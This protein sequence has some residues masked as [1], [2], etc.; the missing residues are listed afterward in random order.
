MENKEREETRKPGT[1]TSE[2]AKEM[3]ARS[4]ESRHRNRLLRDALNE[5]LMRPVKVVLSDGSVTERERFEQ[6]VRAIGDKFVQGD[7]D[8]VKLY[9]KLNGELADRVQLEN[10]GQPFELKVVKVSEDMRDKINE[11]LDGSGLD[12]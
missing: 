6:G 1:F 10:G 8:V 2:N 9:A 4:A 5:D 12:R 11:Y 3:Q 7:I